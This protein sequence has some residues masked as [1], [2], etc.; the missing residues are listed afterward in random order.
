MHFEFLKTQELAPA[1]HREV[2]AFLDSQSTSHPFQYPNWTG[3]RERDK[4]EDTYC[5]MVR[6]QEE[7]RWFAHCGVTLPAGRW[8]RSIRSLMVYRGPACDDAELTLYGLGKL[9]EKSRELG[10]AYVEIS[11][12]WVER[13]EWSAGGT[14]SRDGWQLLPEC[15][16]SLRL[17]LAAGNDELLRSFRKA[18]RYEIRRSE[19]QGIVIRFAQDEGDLEKFQR[20]YFAMAKKKDFVALEQGDLSHILRRILSERD[21]GALLLAFKETVLLGGTLVVRAAQRSWYVLGA[22]T[23]EDGLSAGHLLQWHAIRWAKEHGCADYD[24]GGYREG[25][26][27][28]PALFKRGFCQTVVQFSPAY[29]YPVDRR[30][31]SILDFIHKLS[32]RLNDRLQ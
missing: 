23:K 20:I 24:F 15:R 6:E 27:T 3:Q 18:T 4:R 25:I 29:R 16:S 21:R 9:L 31:C 1:V 19:Q 32:R 12:D 8:L 2:E 28:G 22:T 5:A 10:F 17:N 26:N 14:L 30:L 11:P 13:P 7:M